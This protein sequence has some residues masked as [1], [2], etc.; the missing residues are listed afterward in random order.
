VECEY[1]MHIYLNQPA[2]IHTDN[3]NRQTDRIQRKENYNRNTK[4]QVC[5]EKTVSH[6]HKL[7]LHNNHAQDST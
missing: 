7:G 1:Y 2:G 3:K 6:S 5:K 4:K